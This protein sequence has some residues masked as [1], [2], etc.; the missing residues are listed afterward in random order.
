MGDCGQQAG[1][2]MAMAPSGGIPAGPVQGVCQEAGERKG[3]ERKGK[4][5]KGE[6]PGKAKAKARRKARTVQT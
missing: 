4:E 5:R 2:V 1:G 6:Q 3:Q